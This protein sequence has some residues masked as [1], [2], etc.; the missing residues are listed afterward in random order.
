[1]TQPTY[2]WKNNRGI[3]FFRARIPKQLS[4]YFTGAE[5]KKS[6]Q[7]DSYRLAVKLARVY[8]VKLDEEMSKLAKGVYGAFQVTLEGK[9]KAKLPDGTEKLVEGKIERNLASLDELPAHKAYLLK[10]L[11]EEAERIERQARENALFQAQ[12]A[13]ITPPAPAQAQTN[14]PERQAESSTLYSEVIRVYLE[15]GE[16]TGRWKPKTKDQ[17]EASLKLFQ[18]IT[19]DLPIESINKKITREFKA[20]YL[21]IP[22]NR[23]KKRQYRDKTI[24]ELLSMEIPKEDLIDAGTV[25]SNMTRIG[26]FF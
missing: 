1:M 7:T 15:E 14:P 26:G 21:K 8:R 12:L 6:L 2:L 20:Q 16:A 24:A 25:H 3:Y 13:A 18:E 23:N 9:V 4:D 10:Q 19:G 5:I 11:K 17:V 22:S